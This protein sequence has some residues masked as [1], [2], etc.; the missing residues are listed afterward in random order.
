MTLLSLVSLLIIEAVVIHYSILFGKQ[1]EGRNLTAI[2]ASLNFGNYEDY[3]WLEQLINNGCYA[4]ALVMVRFNKEDE[5]NSL[6]INLRQANDPSL[7]K[8]ISDR[9]KTVLG[10]P[11]PKLP[12]SV[13][14]PP[15]P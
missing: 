3:K 12:L 15:C 5:L 8:Y 13:T 10:G 1:V 6:G 14:I 4:S 7:E 2:Q 11:F 9:D